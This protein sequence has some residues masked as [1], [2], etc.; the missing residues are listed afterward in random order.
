MQNFTIL[1]SLLNSQTM[2]VSALPRIY[3]GVPKVIVDLLIC[4]FTAYKP[5]VGCSQIIVLECKNNSFLQLNTA[6]TVIFC[7]NR[8]YGYKSY[9][10]N[11]TGIRS[12]L[13][14]SHSGSLSY[15]H[16]H[17]PKSHVLTLCKDHGRWHCCTLI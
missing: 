12:R 6:L 11:W 4:F 7:D 10:L 9:Y 2:N 5:F 1:A 13:P 17:I 8:F 16:S 3:S 14:I 15:Y